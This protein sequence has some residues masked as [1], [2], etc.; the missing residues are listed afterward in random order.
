MVEGVPF[1]PRKPL[2]VDSH[3][4]NVPNEGNGQQRSDHEPADDGLERGNRGGALLAFGMFLHG[5]SRN[6]PRREIN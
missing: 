3:Q 4:Q 6:A 2:G 1:A 5:I